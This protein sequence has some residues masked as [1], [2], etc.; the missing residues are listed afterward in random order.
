MAPSLLLVR[1][2]G[3]RDGAIAYPDRP[4]RAARRGLRF[5]A[6]P[7]REGFVYR[8]T[9]DAIDIIAGRAKGDAGAG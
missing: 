5:L 8:S 9:L 1:G 7:K 2:C 6:A 3:A 4:M